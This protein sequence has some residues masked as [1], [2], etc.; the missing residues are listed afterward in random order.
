M[1][2]VAS[3]TDDQVYGWVKDVGTDA[4]DFVDETV[5]GITFSKDDIAA[6]VAIA[7]FAAMADPP[8]G[9]VIA[10][11]AVALAVGGVLT[12]HWFDG[13]DEHSVTVT[14][15]DTFSYNGWT[16]KWTSGA[17]FVAPDD[18]LGVYLQ[19]TATA[20][21]CSGR[22]D[23]GWASGNLTAHG[24]PVTGCE[25]WIA[26]TPWTVV[27]GASVQHFDMSATDN[28]SNG[29]CPT[30]WS[31]GLWG[32]TGCNFEYLPLSS[33]DSHASYGPVQAGS[34]GS[35]DVGP[36]TAP[37]PTA[38]QK[39]A[40]RHAIVPAGATSPDDLTTQQQAA[41]VAAAKGIDPSFDGYIRFAMP[42]CSGM[43]PGTCLSAMQGLGF[44]GTLNKTTVAV[45]AADFTKAPC[46]ILSTVP[47]AG[48]A[49]S[50]AAST[51]V[52]ANTNP[53]GCKWV[54]QD[55]H[56]SSG[57]PGAVDVKAVAACDYT[58][59]IVRTLTLWKCSSEP[60][61]DLEALQSGTWGCDEVATDPVH[62]RVAQANEPVTFQA[63]P[64]GGDIIP[65]D[66]AWFIAYGTLDK[67]TPSSTFSNIVQ[68]S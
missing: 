17:G 60:S 33:F 32:V 47:A 67:G 34:A 24:S 44:T 61:A 19:A 15:T 59:S 31:G 38:E 7:R 13:S 63:P 64:Q 68:L 55:P 39:A 21:S 18:R 2:D 43:A 48:A 30:T 25:G 28:Y 45:D 57:T 40:A 62:E 10:S 6:V 20:G 9:L 11:G 65:P 26:M 14:N 42:E 46:T 66:N 27:T 35:V 51:L 1:D 54:V 37:T 49:V 22:F 4:A 56:E 58:T 50:T 36:Y 3:F 8:I 5:Q 52:Q 29:H 23:V 16:G 12:Y 41:V 53:Q